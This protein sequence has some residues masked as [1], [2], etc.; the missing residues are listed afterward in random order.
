M[1]SKREDMIIFFPKMIYFRLVY[2]DFSKLGYLWE[3][4]IGQARCIVFDLK[5][6]VG[7]KSSNQ[8]GTKN[9]NC[10]MGIRNFNK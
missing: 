4:I 8:H 6:C 5:K 3:L 9:A 2:S 1:I 10:S 7:N